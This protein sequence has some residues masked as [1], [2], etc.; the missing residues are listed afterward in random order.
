MSNKYRDEHPLYIWRT[1]N[2]LTQK[3]AAEALGYKSPSGIGYYERGDRGTPKEV[4]ERLE[5]VIRRA[6]NENK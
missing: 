2:N 4:L 3:Q 1:N 6:S 5:F